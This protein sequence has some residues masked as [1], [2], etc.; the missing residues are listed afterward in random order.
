MIFRR[1]EQQ[2]FR[3]DA[4]QVILHT[5]HHKVGTVWFRRVFRALSEHFDIPLAINDISQLPPD[6]P[7]L[8]F[9]RSPYVKPQSLSSYRGSHMIRDPRD[10]VISAYHYHLWTDE[11]WANAPIS[12]MKGFPDITWP[13][14]PVEE[15]QST[16]YV[17]YLNS[18]SRDEG[19]EVELKRCATFVLRDIVDWDYTDPNTYEFRYED[20]MV[21]EDQVFTEIFRHFGFIEDAI[22][23]ALQAIRQHSFRNKTKREIG[24]TE[25]KSHLRSGKLQQWKEE[26]DGEL[27]ETFRHYLGDGLIRLGYETDLN[28]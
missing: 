23:A 25:E 5:A 19:M 28:W 1:A 2:Y 4:P 21:R 6:R 22:P 9:Q 14:H 24:Q 10:I 17:D 7:A 18:L 16:T 27:K 8:F 26:L 15:I 3:P 11:P 13:L 20:I 12:E